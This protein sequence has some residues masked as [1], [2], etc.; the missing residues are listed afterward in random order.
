M[1]E[2]DI[3]E[4]SITMDTEVPPHWK[5]CRFEYTTIHPKAIRIIPIGGGDDR[6]RSILLK[7]IQ[8]AKETIM[9]CSFILS[10]EEI[11]KEILN[12][13]K[14]NVRC[15]L[16]F[17]TEVQLRKEYNTDITEFN[18]KT[19]TAHKK[20]LDHI[21]GKALARTNKHLHAKF[22]LVDYGTS[23]QKGYLSTANF[24]YDALTRNQEVGVIMTNTEIEE[25]FEFFRLGFWS[26]S[27]QELTRLNS[28]DVVKPESL[29]DLEEFTRIR[30]TSSST[31]GIK[32]EILN[33]LNRTKG[34]LI[35]SSYGFESDHIVVK[36]LSEKA[37]NRKI[38]IITRP[39]EK[40]LAAIK[41]LSN[42]GA[43]IIGYDF[44]HAKFI[45]APEN[46]LAL[47]MTANLETRGLDT[48]YEVGVLLEEP[49]DINEL[50]QISTEWI[51]HAYYKWNRGGNVQTLETGL[52]AIPKAQN[53]EETEII[54][55]YIFPMDEKR[56]ND[57]LEMRNLMNTDLEKPRNESGKIPKIIR[58]TRK[59]HTPLLPQNAQKI[60]SNEYWRNKL[61]KKE[62]KERKI[63]KFPISVYKLKK[64]VYGLVE[65]WKQL[66]KVHNDSSLPQ[67]IKF[68]TK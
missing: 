34:P 19:L 51:K 20:M 65:S 66:D 41:A 68:V 4:K 60:N 31:Q 67:K 64:D 8:E 7:A 61:S 46:N 43:I 1:I 49:Q 32:K 33:I 45:F 21:V 39:R 3:Q 35:I 36:M 17:S 52:I 18:Q 48:G 54:P 16:L 14:R 59:I 62:F 50:H 63:K 29:S 44:L 5:V 15:Y 30:T 2:P 47:I 42:A 38:T 25:L 23:D 57:L 58:F 9:L 24:T 11:I 26:E 28:W 56:P 40:N 10:D 53:I 13:T 6:F 22:L 37:R 27:N 55:E 12:A